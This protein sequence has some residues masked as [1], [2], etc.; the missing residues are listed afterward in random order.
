MRGRDD[1]S[2]GRVAV[3]QWGMIPSGPH[4]RVKDSDTTFFQ[5]RKRPQ[6]KQEAME[7]N[8]IKSLILNLHHS[9]LKVKV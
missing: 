6:D 2:G 4:D 3:W 7:T 9:R 5:G 1:Q 8:E